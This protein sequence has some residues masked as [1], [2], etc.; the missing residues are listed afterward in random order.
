GLVDDRVIFLPRSANVRGSKCISNLLSGGP[1]ACEASD[2]NGMRRRS[3]P[4][5]PPTKDFT[6]ASGSRKPSGLRPLKNGSARPSQKFRR[7]KTAFTTV[8]VLR[9][10]TRRT[11]SGTPGAGLPNAELNPLLD[12][13]PSSA[14]STGESVALSARALERAVNVPSRTPCD[15]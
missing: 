5:T 4:R 14:S 3:S 10:S 6:R 9:G 15:E 12:E 7:L 2:E 13:P 11:V 8:G 1:T